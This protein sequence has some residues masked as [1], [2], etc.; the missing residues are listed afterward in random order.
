MTD[1]ET[2]AADLNAA[3]RAA[4]C[5]LIAMAGKRAVKFFKVYEGSKNAGY[6]IGRGEAVMIAAGFGIAL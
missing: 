2:A 5:P 4:R 6:N 3:F 1:L